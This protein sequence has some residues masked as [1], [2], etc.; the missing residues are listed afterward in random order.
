MRKNVSGLEMLHKKLIKSERNIYHFLTV[1]IL[2]F[3][4]CFEIMIKVVREGVQFEV[5]TVKKR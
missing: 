3:H 4:N 2:T 1:Q 5:I